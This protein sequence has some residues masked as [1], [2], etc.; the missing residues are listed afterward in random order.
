[1]SGEM[2]RE[3]Y[4]K[5]G[6]YLVRNERTEPGIAKTDNLKNSYNS[7]YNIDLPSTYYIAGKLKENVAPIPLSLF[8]PH[9][10]PW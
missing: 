10:L 7:D 4:I 8:L 5:E 3:S 1:M 6:F 2:S 9:I